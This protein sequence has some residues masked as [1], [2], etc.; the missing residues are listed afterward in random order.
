MRAAT[1]GNNSPIGTKE[2]HYVLRTLGPAACRDPDLFPAVAKNILRVSLPSMIKRD[3]DEGRLFS[4]TAVQMLKALPAKPSQT[5]PL[6]GVIK[7]V[8]FDLLNALTVKPVQPEEAGGSQDESQENVPTDSDIRTV[9]IVETTG[10]LR[11][12]SSND[13]LQQDDDDSAV[14]VFHIVRGGILKKKT[15]TIFCDYF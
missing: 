5:P 12:V 8:I 6:E 10:L 3:E 15:L 14:I 9:G 13:I 2:M 7:E 1:L 11:D 4:S